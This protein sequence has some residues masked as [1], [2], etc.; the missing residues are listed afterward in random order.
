MEYMVI[1]QQALSLVA[2]AAVVFGLSRLKQYMLRLSQKLSE[3]HL[4][5]RYKAQ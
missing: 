1:I 3:R 4:S 2:L 5:R